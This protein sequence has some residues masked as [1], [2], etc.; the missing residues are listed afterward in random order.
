M[1]NKEERERIKNLNNEELHTMIELSP[2]RHR[3]DAIGNNE[4]IQ[5]VFEILH[6]RKEI[7]C[8]TAYCFEQHE[9]T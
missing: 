7:D 1:L 8:E 4:T 9:E 5:F 3:G 6:N 2:Y